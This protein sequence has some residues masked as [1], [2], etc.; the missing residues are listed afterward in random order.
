[1]KCILALFTFLL[2]AKTVNAQS[3]KFYE[4]NLK[5]TSNI[6]GDHSLKNGSSIIINTK[7]KTI[8]Y[9]TYEPIIDMETTYK[10]SYSGYS[11]VNLLETYN[12][13]TDVGA[14]T[15]GMLKWNMQNNKCIL[16]L[17]SIDYEEVSGVYTVEA[18]S[19]VI[20]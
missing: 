6:M 19:K 7:E 2:F 10:F 14:I 17:P 3:T 11:S 8:G 13:G 12:F 20:E 9:T 16:Q 18:T 1:M 5:V 15:P 4:I